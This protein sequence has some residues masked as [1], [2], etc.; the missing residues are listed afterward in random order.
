MEV[1]S[2]GYRIKEA[3]EAAGMTQTALAQKSGVSRA[4]IWALE[5]GDKHV[6]T[7]KTLCKIAKALGVTLEDLFARTA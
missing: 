4:T 5:T 6:T 1:I 7:T 2:L 3:R